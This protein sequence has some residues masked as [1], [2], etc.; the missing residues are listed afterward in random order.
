M[1]QY[2]EQIKTNPM[3]QCVT[4][5]PPHKLDE[6]SVCERISFCGKIA[7]RKELN[8]RDPIDFVQTIKRKNHGSVLEHGYLYLQVSH[9]PETL[10]FLSLLSPYFS[11]Y[12]KVNSL[13]L[14]S[15]VLIAG[16]VRA[17]LNWW[18]LPRV[19]ELQDTAK[20]CLSSQYPNLFSHPDGNQA[21]FHPW[22]QVVQNLEH[23]PI[24]TRP[25]TAIV[26]TDRGTTHQLV[27]HRTLSFTQE[28]TRFVDYGNG[29]PYIDE[30]DSG[31]EFRERRWEFIK[32]S[33]EYYRDAL[34]RGEK[35]ETAR[36]FLPHYTASRIAI[37]GLPLHWFQ[38]IETRSGKDSQS[39]IRRISDHMYDHIKNLSD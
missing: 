38:F 1:K 19:S 39:R 31:S 12:M 37:T 9:R 18:D 25:I 14:E 24:L 33:A 16:N 36:D 27:R 23:L 35:K 2:Q 7:W 5:L 26:D 13:D 30:E 22:I 15:Y 8:D 21:L 6:L 20:Y 34:S 17:W 32:M 3:A 11:I 10:Q 29:L 28:S 4:I